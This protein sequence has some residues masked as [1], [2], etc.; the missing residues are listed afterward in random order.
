MKTNYLKILRVVSLLV[1]LVS[2][3]ILLIYHFTNKDIS[4]NGIRLLGI[5]NLIALP[6]LSFTSAKKF[7]KNH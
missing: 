3:V 5:L 1:I 6:L 2:V 4:D 7:T